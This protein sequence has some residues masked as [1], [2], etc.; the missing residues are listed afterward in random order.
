M[1]KSIKIL[2]ISSLSN[3]LI[4]AIAS[5]STVVHTLNYNYKAGSGPD[6]SSTL[7]GFIEI[8]TSAATFSDNLMFSA[9]FSNFITNLSLTHT[10][11][12]SVVTTMTLSDLGALYFDK[13][14]GVTVNFSSD[15]VSQFDN[16]N[17][18]AASSGLPTASS[19]EFTMGMGDDEYILASTPSPVPFLGILF[20]IFLTR[21]KR[22]KNLRKRDIVWLK[23]KH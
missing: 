18:V 23:T 5:A 6:S 19:D 4:P 8:D 20:P 10:T 7:T 9:T 11:G 12:S 1:K 22:F 16:I 17:F 21:L 3:L 13:K 15:L 2:L 14:D